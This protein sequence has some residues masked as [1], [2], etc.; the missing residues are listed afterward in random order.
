[1]KRLKKRKTS[2]LN[3]SWNSDRH[4][5]Y[6]PFCQKSR[7]HYKNVQPDL[8]IVNDSKRKNIYRAPM[9]NLQ[10]VSIAPEVSADHGSTPVS[11]I[12]KKDSLYVRIL[13]LYI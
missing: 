8:T 1:M 10:G 3:V 6:A 4:L 9:E 11:F 5:C 12:I 13:L 7:N 2:V